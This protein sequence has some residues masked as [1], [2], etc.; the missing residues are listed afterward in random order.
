MI[1]I[2]YIGHSAFYLKLWDK[3][4]LFDP[5]LNSPTARVNEELSPHYIFVSHGHSDHGFR[6][7]IEIAKKS[8]AKFV[9]VFELVSKANPSHPLPGNIGGVIKDEIEIYFA[10]ALH[11]CPFAV[12]TG[13]IVSYKGFTLYH[14]G[15]TGLFSDMKLLGELYDIDLAFLPIG[16]TYTMSTREANKAIELLNPKLVVPMHYNTFPQIKAD[17]SSLRGNILIMNPGDKKVLSP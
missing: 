4:L 9:G 13:F 10:P 5:W 17:P 14:A 8:N 3:L 1:E 2:N 7:A 16:G 12:P 15:D 6:E 11:S